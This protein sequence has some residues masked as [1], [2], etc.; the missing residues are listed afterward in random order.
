M[1]LL[2]HDLFGEILTLPEPLNTNGPFTIA[3]DTTHSAK[4]T[5]S[6]SDAVV[7]SSSR[8]ITNSTPGDARMKSYLRGLHCHNSQ[9]RVNTG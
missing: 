7:L 9:M 8:V 4:F 6:R 5:A 1:K 3:F 2:R